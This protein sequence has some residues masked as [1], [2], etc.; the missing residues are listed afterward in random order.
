MCGEMKLVNFFPYTFVN[1]VY[2]QSLPQEDSTCSPL[3]VW[4]KLKLTMLL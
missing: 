1:S 4:E 2:G 3:C